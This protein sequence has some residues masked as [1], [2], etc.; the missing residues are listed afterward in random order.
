VKKRGLEAY[1]EVKTEVERAIL[2]TLTSTVSDVRKCGHATKHQALVRRTLLSSVVPGDASSRKIVS[3]LSRY[4]QVERKTIGKASLQRRM[5]EAVSHHITA[6][7]PPHPI[8]TTFTTAPT[9]SHHPT[10]TLLIIE[11]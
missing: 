1:F 5:I 9:P 4:F 2:E 10:T 11:Y 6:P 7:L 3:G 8:T